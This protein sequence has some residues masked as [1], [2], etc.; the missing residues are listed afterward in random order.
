MQ[1]RF[2]PEEWNYFDALGH[3]TTNAPES[4]NWRVFLKTG[5]RKPN[6]YT[7][8]GV[9]KDDLKETERILDQLE[10]GKLE[11]RFDKKVQDKLAQKARLKDMLLANQISLKK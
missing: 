7:S 4:T 10:A 8:V 11:K 6:V 1:G 9:I 5:T 2:D 3:T